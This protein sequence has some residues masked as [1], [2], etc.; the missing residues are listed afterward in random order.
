MAEMSAWV[1]G[2]ELAPDRARTVRFSGD[3]LLDLFRTFVTLVM[4]TR[5]LVE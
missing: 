4:L 1:R 5:G 2:V 3:D